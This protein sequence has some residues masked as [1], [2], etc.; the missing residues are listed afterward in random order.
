[1][2][3]SKN[4]NTR[5]RYYIYYKDENG[6]RK[7]ISTG[8]AFKT[9]ALA[10]LISF[11]SKINELNSQIPKT[12]PLKNFSELESNVINYVSNNLRVGTV[13]IYKNVLN[14]FAKVIGEKQFFIN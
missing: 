8:S 4:K 9:E 6:K 1:M 11:A 2:F 5:G 7:T 13:R 10:Y 3:L 12:K 14:N